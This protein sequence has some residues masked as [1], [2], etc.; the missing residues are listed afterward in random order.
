MPLGLERALGPRLRIVRPGSLSLGATHRM[1]RTRLGLTLTRP[2]LRRVHQASGGNPLFIL[3]I[4]RDLQGRGEMPGADESLPIPSDVRRILS[5]RIRRLS[6][7]G[8]EAV[9]AAALRGEPNEEIVVR[10]A[11]SSGL[12]EALTAGILERDEDELRFV[13]PL[14]AEAATSLT[15]ER[16][17][18]EMHLRL[19]GLVVEPDVRAQHLA[20]GSSEPAAEV[21]AALE[22]A[23]EAA[24]RRGAPA[25]AA[26]LAEHAARLTPEDDLDARARRT[27][28]AALSWT[29]AGD[30]KRCVA[31]LEPL[32]SELPPGIRRVDAVYAR[33]R[34]IEDRVYRTELEE[35]V[36]EADG[37]PGGQVRLLFLLCY[38]LV[39]GLDFPAA[40]ERARAAV[41]VAERSGDPSL[42]V[43]ALGMA[44]RLEIGRGCLEPLRRA[45]ALESDGT[46]VDAYESPATWLGWWLLANDELDAA[47]PLLEAQHRRAVD[48]GDEWNRTFLHWPLT[49]LECRAGNYQAARS[50]ATTGL[51]LAE[52]GDNHYAVSA[53]LSCRALVAAH[54]GERE[55]A[56]AFA[57]ESLDKAR[58]LGSEL[59]AARPRIGLGFLAVSE[60][61]YA[62]ALHHLDGLAALALAGPFWST[63]PV[64]VDLF[65]A[66]VHQGEVERARSLLADLDGHLQHRPGLAP[67]IAHCRGLVAWTSGSPDEGIASL[68][69]A[70]SLEGAR[71][72]FDRARTLLSLGEMQRRVQRRRAARESLR[73]A[74]AQFESL[75]AVIWAERARE[76]L[77]RVGGRAPSSGALTPAERRVA[78]L[79]ARGHSNKE[80]AAELVVT[81]R[82][83]EST[84]TKI[85]RK[86]E[87]RSRAE[88]AHRLASSNGLEWG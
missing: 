7:P 37:Y 50:Y 30:T 58:G 42:L 45:R 34:A 57:E 52:Q 10:A 81:V 47:R 25:S 20:L 29:D 3:E 87:V 80:V 78:E 82:T 77:A 32:L 66:L 33:A 40:R 2:A 68:E 88:L 83:V 35:A 16:R 67:T 63:Y 53:L 36:A 46:G 76:E 4:G 9:L 39:H 44:G 61:R 26:A 21:A 73:E 24:R 14:F 27:I 22:G 5:S 72:L 31:L 69:E 19:A 12:E 1:L 38:A 64:W 51:E 15:P 85:Y 59:F 8:R 48:D 18:R 13:H 65:E 84:L 86:L 28:A 6:D 74:G 54:L 60:R 43:L 75:G 23:A 49:E 70:L 62:D 79:V 41:Q 71:P 55:A 17:R 56:R 11:G